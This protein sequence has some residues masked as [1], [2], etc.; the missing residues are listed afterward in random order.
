SAGKASA[1]NEPAAAK[2]SPIT[3]PTASTEATAPTTPTPRTSPAIPGAGADKHSTHKPV[4]P[5]EAVRRAR[6][7]I[8]VVVSPLAYRRPANISVARSISHAHANLRLRIRQRQHQ[9]T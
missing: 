7:W 3:V 8:I 5:I 6:V 9:N 4:G 2:P 1:T